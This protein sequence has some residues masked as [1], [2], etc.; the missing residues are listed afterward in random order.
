MPYFTIR[1]PEDY[2]S[3]TQIT[4]LLKRLGIA[5]LKQIALG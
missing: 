1:S 3:S 4:D 5:I 2:L